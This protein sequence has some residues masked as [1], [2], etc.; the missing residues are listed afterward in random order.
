[1]QK[2]TASIIT[3]YELS[4]EWQA[5]ADSNLDEWAEDAMYLEPDESHNPCDHVL[6]DLSECMTIRGNHEG[7]NFNASIGISN[8]SA[9]LLHISDDGES[10]EYIFA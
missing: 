5:E 3:Y 10:A 8:N 2:N 1:M 6:W 9:M 4:D 7:F